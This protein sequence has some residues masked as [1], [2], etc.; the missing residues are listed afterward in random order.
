MNNFTSHFFLLFKNNFLTTYIFL[1]SPMIAQRKKILARSARADEVA[2]KGRKREISAGPAVEK[3][4]REATSEGRK[5]GG[6]GTK[7]D[8]KW[9]VCNFAPA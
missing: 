6:R 2:R 3:R 9:A 1:Y 4:T 5:K 8:R 7:N